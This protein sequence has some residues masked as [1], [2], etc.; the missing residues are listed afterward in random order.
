MAKNN[1]REGFS[2]LPRNKYIFPA[3]SIRTEK[4]PLMEILVPILARD[5][6]FCTILLRKSTCGFSHAWQNSR[7]GHTPT[8]STGWMPLEAS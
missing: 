5:N 7:Q 3:C 8:P 2:T 4:M 6:E 1:S